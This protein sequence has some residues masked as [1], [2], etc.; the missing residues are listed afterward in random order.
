MPE[1]LDRFERIE[2]GSAHELRDW[3]ASNSSSSTSVWLVTSRKHVEGRHLAWPDLV[4][5]LLCFGWIDSLPRKL[6]QDRTMHLI[7]PRKPGS[8]W[9]AINKAKVERLIAAGRMTAKGLAAIEAAKRDG[10]WDVLDAAD[11]DNP[12]EDLVAAMTENPVAEGFFS[13]FPRSSKRAILEWIT[14]AKTPETRARRIAET[15][16]LASENRKANHPKG[17]D[18]GPKPK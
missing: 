17:R 14:L 2:V 16:R 15:V 5:E 1:G 18:A 11:P 7:S 6:D 12:P 3:L 9:S 13:R 10:S 4:D 8:G